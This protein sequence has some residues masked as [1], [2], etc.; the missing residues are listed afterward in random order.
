MTAGSREQPGI[1]PRNLRGEGDRLRGE[2][3][4]AASEMIAESGDDSQL[5]LRGV[6]K[7]VGIAAPSIY[8]H[9]PDVEHLKM[10]VVQRAFA[11]FAAARD[12]A[13]QD[14]ADP[15]G[16]LL[17]RCRAYC[18]FALDHPG[19]YRFMF[20]H[21]TP[22]DPGASPPVGAAAFKGLAGSIRR[23]QEAGVAHAPDDPAHLAAQVWAAL[24]G[25]VLLRMNAPEFPWPA[26]LT[27]MTDQA[28]SRLI[29][30]DTAAPA[31]DRS[32]P[33]ST[34]YAIVSHTG[35]LFL[36]FSPAAASTFWAI[37]FLPP[38]V[39]VQSARKVTVSPGGHMAENLDLTAA[40]ATVRDEL[41]RAATSASD[42]DIRFE[43]GDVTMEFSVEMRKDANAK[44]GFTAWVITAGAQGGIARSDTH[45][46]TISLHPHLPGGKPVEVSESSRV[47]TSKF[48]HRPSS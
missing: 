2:L 19:P 44:F 18:Q 11:T 20:S 47:G 38:R 32:P 7:R 36:D 43:V 30:L 17:A 29:I 16:A 15:A 28:V 13:D 22:R 27:E 41:L 4:D 40:V 8:R 37:T 26:P 24:H 10:A 46:V 39:E 35:V 9:F 1:R 45:K 34:L 48:G 14:A 42:Q 23:C 3:V 25:M 31:D 33:N 21:R 5:T 6:A 12:S